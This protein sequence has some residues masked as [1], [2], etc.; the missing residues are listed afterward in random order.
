MDAASAFDRATRLREA[1]DVDGLKKL[2]ASGDAEVKA[3][4]LNGL[5]L[6]PGDNPDMGPGILALAVEGAAHPSA[7][8]RES[9]CQV[10]KDQ[11]GWGVDVASAISPLLTLLGDSDADVRRMAAFALGNVCKRRFNLS[12]HF[13]A[14]RR[15]LR[16]KSLYVPEAAAW[17][18]AQM[19]RAKH[20]IGP[21]VPDLV[22]VLAK[23]DEYNEP[24]KESA[25]ALLHHAKKSEEGRDQ[26]RRAVA[27]VTL[28]IQR[29]EIKRFL[30]QLGEL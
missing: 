24:Q 23:D 30:D 25:K 16:D 20:D 15:L 19:S 12:R 22:R 8:V 27:K 29:K 2:F 13:A 9:A 17:A 18:L 5:C 14:L 21:A 4:V 28:D 11:S 1:G 6:E 10:F 7:E 3:G 26:V